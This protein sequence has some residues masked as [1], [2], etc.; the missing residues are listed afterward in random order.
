MSRGCAIALT[1]PWRS[2]K[3]GFM[4]TDKYNRYG[5]RLQPILLVFLVLALLLCSS[6]SSILFAAD[7]TCNCDERLCASYNAAVLDAAGPLTMEKISKKLIAI[8]ADNKD[9]IWEDDVAGSRV[10]VAIYSWGLNPDPG[11]L[12]NMYYT[13]KTNKWVTVV[14]E[15]HDFFK[16]RTFTD[17]RIEQALGL[18]PCYGNTKIIEMYV[19]PV[20]MF[21]PSPDPET[22]D[23][24][25]STE[26]PWRTSR[27]VSYNPSST[28]Y[29]DF[30]GTPP[31]CYSDYETWFENRRAGVYT[32]NPPYP[33]TGL[34]YT[35]DWG[36]TNDHVG[37]SEFV[38]LPS[39]TG[40]LRMS[41]AAE[42]FRNHKEVLTITKTGNGVVSSKPYGINCGKTCT[43]T[44][45]RYTK[46]ALT[47]KASS[48]SQFQGWTG[49]C[50]HAGTSPV[51]V[52]TM[53]SAKSA[54]AV[55]V[56][57]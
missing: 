32:A 49:A 55:F 52:V 35:Y 44:F 36:K 4:M 10:L 34:G 22:T 9:L 45:N 20:N 19:S 54:E 27:F 47:A 43:K 18:P 26:F 8:T 6:R 46:V 16:T 30:C 33:W 29:D 31:P 17:T 14:P 2:R 39:M 7:W 37:L 11:E 15:L 1:V 40:V 57:K 21:R 28:I 13:L 42:Y 3:G 51:C 23:Q 24:E 50:I 5:K 38:V 25:A 41:D 48:S 12:P 53:V 56:S